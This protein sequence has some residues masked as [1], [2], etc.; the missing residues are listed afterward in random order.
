M[1]MIENETKE[2][3]WYVLR[4][5]SNREETVKE[6]LERRIEQVGLTGRIPRV[7]VPTERI[8]EIKGGKRRVVSR[9]LYPGY[10]MAQMVLDDDAWFLVKETPG[11]GDFVGGAHQY[12]KPVPMNP[13]EASRVLAIVD[14]KEDDPAVK[15]DFDLGDMVKIKEGTFENFNGRVDEVNAE[16]G[17]VKVT[18]TIFGRA[19]PIEM[20]YWK[21]EKV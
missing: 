13:Q 11:I 4:V 10:I 5:Q 15:I 20:E 3:S 16:K 21:L 7:L 8:T 2:L 19:T 12:A 14:R 6:A 1:I 9:K 17:L 18:V